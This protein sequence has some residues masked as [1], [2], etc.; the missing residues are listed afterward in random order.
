MAE[1]LQTIDLDPKGETLVSEIK[2]FANDLPFW[3]KYLADKI[4]SG[5][6]ISD[7]EIETSHRYLLEELQLIEKCEKPVIEINYSPGSAN[8]F[9][10]DL[11]LS[12]IEDVEGVNALVEKQL[13]EFG[14]NLTVLYGGNGSGKSGYVRLLKKAFYSKAP[15]EI[16]PNIHIDNGHKETNA[17]FSFSSNGSVYSL[18][19]LDK[20]CIE[21]QQFAVFDGKSVIR[22]LEQ[23][24]EFEFRP[25][26][27]SFFPEYSEAVKKVE[28]KMTAEIQNRQSE[29]DFSLWFDGDSEIKTL[30]MN[31]SATTNLETLKKFTPFSE[32]EMREKVAVQKKIDELLLVSKNKE[33]EIK[34]LEN[35][36]KLLIENK[37]TITA[38]NQSFSEKSITKLEDAISEFINIDATAKAEGFESFATDKVEGI[39]T[40]EW[41]NFILAAEVFAR[42]QTKKKGHYPE[43]GD[44]CLLCHQPLS[45]DA[46]KL[47]EKYWKFIKST[48]EQNVIVARESLESIKQVLKKLNFDLFQSDNVLT[49][50]L[51]E[52]HQQILETLK[53]Q[54]SE[55]KKLCENFISDLEKR[56]K[57]KRTVMQISLKE[58]ESLIVSI[59]ESLKKLKENETDKEFKTLVKEKTFLEHKEKFNTHYSKFEAY[60][61][62]QVWIKKASKANFSKRKITE[63]E[64]ALSNKY[65]NQ[66]YIT[67]FDEECQKLNGNFGVEISHTG[68]AGKSFRQLKLKG[69][70]PNAVL[71]EGEQKVIAIADF[72]AEME[73][74]EINRG[75]IFDDPVNSLDSDRK[76]QIAE[77]LAQKALNKQIIIFT[78][79]L[80]FFYHLR[81]FSKK[82]LNSLPNSLL[83]HSI[84]RHNNKEAGRVILNESPAN[85]G[86]FTKPTKAEEWLRKSKQCSGSDRT[87][88]VRSGMSAL[89]SS[90]E[91]LAIFI[92]L[93]GTVQRFDPQIRM[94]RLKDVK[95]DKQLI[96]EVVEK[97][98]EISDLID[99]HL[100]SDEVAFLPTPDDLEKQLKEFT[101]LKEK[102]AK[103]Q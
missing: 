44:N 34:H 91:A 45:N 78:H 39:G 64:K 95:Y 6:P 72:L 32:E 25:A 69:K 31:L 28:Q 37:D 29:N 2:K 19:I 1:I 66:K 15:E 97:F 61:N 85:E 87:N 26:G 71:S 89:R 101:E 60:I 83:H 62:D 93:G 56:S 3:A 46:E 33:K 65:F 48:A 47:I 41:K 81:N 103:I 49:V 8:N 30:V 17:K 88:C 59:E 5:V 53:S 57:N 7:N 23:K 58:I 11:L 35:I 90:Y 76:K 92:I 79:D 18:K 13:I 10:Y 50:W 63:T 77:R 9:K 20:N 4:L 54:L 73:L 14:P 24:N 12:K 68:A 82:H 43:K 55:Q 52:N 51:T 102:I 16:L 94:G 96:N 42:N 75:L 74:S 99:A 36:L 22:H 67:A 21:F 38:I 100:Q 40:T 80:V 98:G 27:L 70:N 84:E 86:Q